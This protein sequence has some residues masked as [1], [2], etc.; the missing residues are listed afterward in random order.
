MKSSIDSIGTN[1][2]TVIVMALVSGPIVDQ[3]LV[4]IINKRKEIF[5]LYI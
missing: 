5:E 2:N 4:R 3:P 1:S